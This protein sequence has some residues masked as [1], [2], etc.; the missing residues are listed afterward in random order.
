MKLQIVIA[1]VGGQGVLFAARL[2]YHL[3]HLRGEEVF[4]AETHGMSQRGGSV[5]SYVKI[6]SFTSPLIRRGRADL[7]LGLE[8]EEGLRN[9][10]MLHEGGAAV[11][12]AR[13][14]PKVE[15]VELYPVE[16]DLLAQEV[17][18]PRTANLVLM[19]FAASLGLL[20]FSEGEILEAVSQLVPP[21]LKGVNVEAVKRGF[22]L[23]RASPS[24]T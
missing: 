7:L 16:A 8:R 11:I 20:P 1:G 21:A 12:N 22:T 2:L 4:G 17:G 14:V 3:A 19:S 6:G 9:L 5:I 15:G 24:L 13:E 18:D 23:G 10:P